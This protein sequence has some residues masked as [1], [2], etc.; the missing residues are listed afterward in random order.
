MLL[1][2]DSPDPSHGAGF[3]SGHSPDTDRMFDSLG[4][5]LAHIVRVLLCIVGIPLG[6]MTLVA[7][8]LVG[9]AGYVLIGLLMMGIGAVVLIA[10]LNLQEHARGAQPPPRNWGAA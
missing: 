3:E 4:E 6:V 8:M 10:S 1:Q 9:G 5:V 2:S 7:G